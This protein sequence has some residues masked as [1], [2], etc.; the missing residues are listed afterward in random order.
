MPVGLGGSKSKR[1]A[2]SNLM[3]GTHK[4]NSGVN[5]EGLRFKPWYKDPGAWGALTADVVRNVYHLLL[6]SAAIKYLFF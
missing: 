4:V 3:A 2:A 6:L 1:V 5:M